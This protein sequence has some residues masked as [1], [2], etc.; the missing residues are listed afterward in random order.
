MLI[1]ILCILATLENHAW[2]RLYRFFYTGKPFISGATGLLATELLHLAVL[3]SER[4]AAI[5]NVKL[6][7]KIRPML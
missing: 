1:G 3:R 2:L 4:K 6:S 7:K 5:L